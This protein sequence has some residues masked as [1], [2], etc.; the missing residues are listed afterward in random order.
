MNEIFKDDTL[1]NI[2]HRLAACDQ[3]LDIHGP[4]ISRR[5]REH[6]TGHAQVN[7]RKPNTVTQCTNTKKEHELQE[8]NSKK[9]Q[10]I[11]GKPFQNVGKDVPYF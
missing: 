5:D 4:G 11:I 7:E 8:R 2:C 6:R 10:G 9:E 3:T 1:G